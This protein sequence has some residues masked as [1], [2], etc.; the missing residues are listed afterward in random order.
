MHTLNVRQLRALSIV[1]P[2]TLA[3]R[4]SSTFALMTFSLTVEDA[5]RCGFWALHVNQDGDVAHHYNANRD[6]A[7]A[8]RIVWT[9]YADLIQQDADARMEAMGL[10]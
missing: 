2:G 10:H 9:S 6:D 4:D 8:G 5:D 7:L 1:A 3:L